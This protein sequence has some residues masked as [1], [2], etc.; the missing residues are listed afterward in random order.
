MKADWKEEKKR[1]DPTHRCVYNMCMKLIELLK[2][3]IIY[4]RKQHK[5][6]KKKKTRRMNQLKD[7]NNNNIIGNINKN[8]K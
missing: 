5:K 2:W 4:V 6:K 3:N 8:N 7:N 1:K